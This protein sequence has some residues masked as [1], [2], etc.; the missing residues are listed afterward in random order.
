MWLC[1]VTELGRRLIMY[2]NLGESF[3]H[4]SNSIVA[5]IAKHTQ[6]LT[7]AHVAAVFA[8]LAIYT[9]RTAKFLASFSC[10]FCCC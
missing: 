3:R 6:A 2:L 1:Y 4:S 8:P 9:N 5:R 10:C 7:H